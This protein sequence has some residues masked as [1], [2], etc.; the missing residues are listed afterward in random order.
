MKSL[1]ILIAD[2]H[3]VVRRGLRAL[4]A[5][6]TN[7]EVAGEATN[8]RQAV[9]EAKRLA[10]D[11]VIMDITMPEMNGLEATRQIRSAVPQAQILI[12]SVHDSEQLVHEVLEAGARGYML[13][14]DAGRDLIVAIDALC[15]NRPF[16]TARVSE[17]VLEGFL[18]GTG[19]SEPQAE[20]LNPLTSREREVM[21]LLAEGKSNKEVADILNISVKTVETHRSRI[22]T[23]LKLHSMN[24]LVRYALRNQF[25]D[26]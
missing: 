25:I 1:R 15:E 2:D 18:K 11:L 26:P 7:W 13:K 19:G 23:K 14:S 3:E 4:L 10:P 17:I 12:L 6:R 5:T 8:G 22:M 24:D 21:Q 16:F 20:A 9:E